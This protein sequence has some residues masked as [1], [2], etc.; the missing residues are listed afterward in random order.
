[1]SAFTSENVTLLGARFHLRR[2]GKG[3]PLLFLHGAG[4]VHTWFPFFQ[5]IAE[6]FELIVPDHPG[7]GASDTPPWLKNIGDAAYF[8]LDLIEHLKLTKPHV[9]G[10]AIGG[11]M[12]AEAAVRDSAPF[13]RLT[14]LAPAGLR[15]IGVPSGDP[16][17][18]SHEEHIR[19][20]YHDQSFADCALAAPVSPEL[21]DIQLKNRYGFARMAWQPR[22][23]NPDLSKWLHRITVPTLIVWGYD[24]KVFPLPYGE[25]Y[26]KL[27]PGSRLEVIKDCGHPMQIE[28]PD[29]LVALMTG[30]IGTH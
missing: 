4:G 3:P 10:S 7:F 13:G 12:A 2:A 22:L 6:S 28:K 23:Y 24:D 18:M 25:A 26:Q 21:A 14:L 8:Y 29:E 15:V 16:F 9:V 17:I 1:M 27:I 11:W 5:K 19:A 30:F 20:L